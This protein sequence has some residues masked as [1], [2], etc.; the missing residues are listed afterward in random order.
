LENRPD[1]FSGED[2]RE[3][4][5]T[6]RAYEVVEPRDVQFEHVAVEEQE[7]AES[8]V[9]GGRRHVVVD[10]QGAQEGRELGRAHVGGVALAVEKNVAADPR[11]VGVLGPPAVVA[12]AEGEAN[13]IQQAGLGRRGA[14]FA[15]A[16]R[17]SGRS[18]TSGRAV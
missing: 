17:G 11:D 10:R 15:D 12:K 18:S 1:F 9:L 5:G 14:S 3:A 2:H 7:R 13:S 6:L 16:R 4:Q 8:L